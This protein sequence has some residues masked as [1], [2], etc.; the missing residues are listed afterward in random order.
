LTQLYVH[1]VINGVSGLLYV[2]A[3]QYAGFFL[4]YRVAWINVLSRAIPNR[5]DAG[6]TKVGVFP[7]AFK[8]LDEINAGL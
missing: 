4:C 8:G 3:E 6:R 5:P 1:K 7:K 2:F